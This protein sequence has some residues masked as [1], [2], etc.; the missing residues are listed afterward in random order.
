MFLED[1]QHFDDGQSFD[2]KLKAVNEDRSFNAIDRVYRLQVIT[3]YDTGHCPRLIGF[4]P[5]VQIKG[6]EKRTPFFLP[7]SFHVHGL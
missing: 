6:Y 1:V 4:L 7:F 5:L 2:F 3:V